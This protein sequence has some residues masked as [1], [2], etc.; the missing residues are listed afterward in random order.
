MNKFLRY[1]PTDDNTIMVNIDHIQVLEVS[2]QQIPAASEGIE[3]EQ[4]DISAI[5]VQVVIDNHLKNLVSLNTNDVPGGVVDRVSH[6]FA[7]FLKSR[8]AV[9]DINNV[10]RTAKL[11]EQEMMTQSVVFEGEQIMG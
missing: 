5:T 2:I 3:T 10:I 6:G 7:T 9:F 11:T 4:D 1:T 8:N